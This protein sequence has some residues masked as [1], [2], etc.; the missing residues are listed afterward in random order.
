MT[1]ALDRAAAAAWATNGPEHVGL[2]PYD[3]LQPK[4]HAEVRAFAAAAL[5]V[6]ADDI[7]SVIN[8]S[9]WDIHP[10][11]FDLPYLAVINDIIDDYLR[12]IND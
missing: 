11:K 1:D 7:R 8:E 12:D 3:E 2:L 6:M 4:R 10:A 9:A 5:R